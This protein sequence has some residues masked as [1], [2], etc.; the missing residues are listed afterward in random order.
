MN[1]IWKVIPEHKENYSV[2]NLGNIKNNKT[3]KLKALRKK[4]GYLFVGLSSA[5]HNKKWFSV[6]RLVALAFIPN[7]ENKGDVNHIDGIKTNNGIENL[8]WATRKENIHHAIR[9]NLF[10]PLHNNLDRTVFQFSKE[11]TFIKEHKGARKAGRELNICSRGISACALEKKYRKSA[12][13]FIWSYN[14][15]LANQGV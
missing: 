2:S 13:G 15:E 9:T 12:G 3:G 11:G 6:H 7:P 5:K 4:N 1:E 8:E 10:N 14:K